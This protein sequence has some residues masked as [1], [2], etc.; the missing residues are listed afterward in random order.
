MEDEMNVATAGTSPRISPASGAGLLFQFSYLQFLD[1]LTTLAFL[2]AGVQEANPLARWL[3]TMTGA[4]LPGL[5]AI[6][7]IAML[8]GLF[9]WWRGRSALLRK[10]NVFFSFVVAWN[11]FCLILGLAK[12]K[13]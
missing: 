4:P 2:L 10:A 3:M 1:I 12:L 7:G 8:I 6:K 13:V 11:L 5:V 9:C